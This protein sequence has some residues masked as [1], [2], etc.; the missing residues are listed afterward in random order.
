MPTET[1]PI[2]NLLKNVNGHFVSKSGVENLTYFRKPVVMI[3]K[4]NAGHSDM[5]FCEVYE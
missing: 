4:I 1:K 5:R 3:M 2:Y